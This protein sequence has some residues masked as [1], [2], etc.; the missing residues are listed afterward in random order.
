M[1]DDSGDGYRLGL[2]KLVPCDSDAV[3][4]LAGFYSEQR[5]AQADIEAW[6]FCM[7][8]QQVPSLREANSSLSIPASARWR[9]MPA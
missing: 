2:N 1:I 9:H 4:R 8:P 6:I 3:L 7:S 5:T